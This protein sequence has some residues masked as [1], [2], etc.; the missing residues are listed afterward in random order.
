MSEDNDRLMEQFIEKAT[1]KLLE[2]LT[3]QVSKQ[4]EDQIGGLKTNAEKMLDEIKDQKR[5]AAEAAAKEQAEAGQFKTL[6]ERKGDPASIKDALSPEPIR[7][8]RV[9]ARDA[10]LYRRAKAQAE[11]VGT[12]LEIVSDD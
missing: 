10:A 8:T 7:L 6:L 1:P 11:K 5:A 3:E 4:I 2:A 9:Q 12:T